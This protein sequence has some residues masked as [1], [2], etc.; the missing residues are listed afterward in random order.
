[1]LL[2]R[3]DNAK[4]F[5]KV[6]TYAGWRGAVI[7]L[8]L[9]LFADIG[10]FMFMRFMIIKAPSATNPFGFLYVT[11]HWIIMPIFGLF[12]IYITAYNVWK[13]SLQSQVFAQ[14]TSLVVPITI[15]Y[16]AV[17]PGGIYFDVLNFCNAILKS[18]FI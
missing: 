13:N 11:S 6:S 12:H 16:L 18:I 17:S 8:L 3:N 10:T 7:L 14:T 2:N 1:M 15:L 4:Y 9:F 5:M